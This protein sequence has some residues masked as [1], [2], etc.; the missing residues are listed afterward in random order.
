MACSG[1]RVSTSG[2]VEPIFDYFRSMGSRKQENYY[3]SFVFLSRAVSPS[4]QSLRV[5]FF[6]Y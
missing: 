2:V 4:P 6:I 3:K 5:V 1:R